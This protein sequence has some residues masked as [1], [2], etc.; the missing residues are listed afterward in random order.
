M[1]LP[2]NINEGSQLVY[3]ACIQFRDFITPYNSFW[4]FIYHTISI[5]TGT[6][7]QG[8]AQKTT[9]TFVVPPGPRVQQEC[10]PSLNLYKHSS[11][12]A[13]VLYQQNKTSRRDISATYFWIPRAKLA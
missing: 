4:L 9:T 10:E 12:G 7:N 13:C 1:V 8:G 2:F 3:D 6:A 11:C 5:L